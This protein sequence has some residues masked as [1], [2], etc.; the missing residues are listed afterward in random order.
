MFLFCKVGAAVSTNP[1]G[2]ALFGFCVEEFF[3]GCEHGINPELVYFLNTF[4]QFFKLLSLFSEIE[5]GIAFLK[6]VGFV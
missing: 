6:R 3:C 2:D 1:R 4:C 5:H